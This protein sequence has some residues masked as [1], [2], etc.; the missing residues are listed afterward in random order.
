MNG[1]S[2][3]T[4]NYTLSLV[5]SLANNALVVGNG[6][7]IMGY[8]IYTHEASFIFLAQSSSNLQGRKSPPSEF[9]ILKFLGLL[10][11]IIHNKAVP[12]TFTLLLTIPLNL[13]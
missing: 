13:P 9:F 4:I 11:Q 6:S 5:A 1:T 3:V 12:I 8:I 7:K 2:N 10:G